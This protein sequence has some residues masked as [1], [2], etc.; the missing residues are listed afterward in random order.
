MKDTVKIDKSKVTM[1][2]LS[3]D[4]LKNISGGWREYTEDGQTVYYPDHCPFC[5]ATDLASPFSGHDIGFKED[6]Y[7]WTLN[8]YKVIPHQGTLL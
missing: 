5:G 2:E 3:D 8:C 4:E 1:V 6:G 7:P